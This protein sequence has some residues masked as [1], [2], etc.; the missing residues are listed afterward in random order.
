MSDTPRRSGRFLRPALATAA[1]LVLLGAGLGLYAFQPW[2]AFTNTTVD[3]AL[4]APAA[5]VSTV[6]APSA[7]AAPSS[8]AAPA[9]TPAPAGPVDLARGG[10]RSGEHTTTGTARLVRLADGSA[11]LRLEGLDTSEGPDVRVYLS[12]LPADRSRRDELGDK[13]LELGKL[14][15]NHGNQNYAV[16]AGTDLTAFHSTVIWCQRFSVTFGA[17]DLAAV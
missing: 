3:E 9:A 14:K 8:A 10:F 12:T 4:P 17:A 1:A 6:P 5:A 7:S 15:G 16:P 13:A 2:K 11:V